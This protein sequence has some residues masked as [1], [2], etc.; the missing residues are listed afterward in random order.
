VPRHLALWILLFAVA[1]APATRV[2]RVLSPQRFV[3]PESTVGG[4]AA[5]VVTT[6][7][8]NDP[9]LPY[10]PEVVFEKDGTRWVAPV[11]VTQKGT[12]TVQPA[13][14][15]LTMRVYRRGVGVVHGDF[16]EILYR[17][18]TIDG[19]L[20]T[21]IRPM[22]NAPL[23]IDPVTVSMRELTS[24]YSD[25]RVTD[26]DLVL[27]ELTTPDLATTERYLFRNVRYGVRSRGGAGALFRIPLPFGEP[28]DEPLPP[29]LNASLYLGYRFRHSPGVVR[30]VEERVM[31][32]L[33]AGI[34]SAVLETQNLDVP[35]IGRSVLVGGGL[36]FYQILS[37]TPVVNASA[38]VDPDIPPT[39][40]LAFG[41]DVVQ[42]TRF[43]Y[44]LASRLW[45]EHPLEEERRPPRSRER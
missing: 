21:A 28:P 35:E 26:R 39:W 16:K 2:R 38:L 30:F 18:G 6:G 15:G 17:S 34:S 33:T 42:L 13:R 25:D 37:V 19:R 5:V 22:P 29:A 31:L 36:E 40:A 7:W 4:E 3:T 1:C 44:G 8:A 23:G 10:H 9:V 27:V 43:T 41:V 20:E 12:I 45:K 32:A 11:E 14:P 24:P